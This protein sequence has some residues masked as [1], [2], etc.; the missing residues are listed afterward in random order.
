MKG[1]IKF[2]CLV[3][4]LIAFW[5]AYPYLQSRNK[6]YENRL[7]G[8]LNLVEEKIEASSEDILEAN[9]FHSPSIRPEPEADVWGV[10][11]QVSVRSRSGDGYQK[12][13]FAAVENLCRTYLERKCWRLKTL[14][15]GDLV[16]VAE[17]AMIGSFVTVEQLKPAPP[18]ASTETGS[19]AGR[20]AAPVP[21]ELPRTGA[22]DKL[23]TR[24]AFTAADDSLS[25]KEDTTLTLSASSLLAN[26]RDV[27]DEAL[28][29]TQVGQP[30]HGALADNADGTYSYTPAPNYHGSD[31]FTYAVSDGKGGSDTA[32]VTLDVRRANTAP[33][34]NNDRTSTTEDNNLTLYAIALLANDSDSDGDALS[35]TG[36]AAARTCFLAVPAVR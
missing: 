20:V 10:S 27:D 33:V 35:I 23:G 30:R 15:V 9:V 32:T 21:S 1:V 29:I 18:D 8:A 5:V 13:Y 17:S 31:S 36:V 6:E 7:V 25:T 16:L 22:S 3:A 26:D 28:S 12:P 19:S 34:A 14:M 2:I 24:F 4:F 11:G